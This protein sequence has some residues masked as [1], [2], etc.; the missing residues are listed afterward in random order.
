MIANNPIIYPRLHLVISLAL[1]FTAGFVGCIQDPE[2][3]QTLVPD[4]LDLSRPDDT[5]PD[6]ADLEDIDTDGPCSGCIPGARCIDEECVVPESCHHIEQLG[7]Q[8]ETG[9]HLIDPPQNQGE[10]V[11]AYCDFEADRG[12]GYTMIRLESEDLGVDPNDYRAACDEIGMELIVPRTRVHAQ[13]ILDFNDNAPPNIVG[14]YPRQDGADGL[15]D[16]KGQCQG[17]PC[18]FYIDDSNSPGCGAEFAPTQQETT[19]IP[20]VRSEDGCFFGAWEH[21]T[22]DVPIQG[23][24]IC[25]PNDAGPSFQPTC[26]EYRLHDSV[27]NAGPAGIS[28]LYTLTDSNG[29]LFQTYCEMR[30]HD[31]GWTLIAVNGTD[32]RPENFAENAYPRPGASRYG[33]LAT[34]DSDV[35]AIKNGAE[36]AS[37]FSISGARLYD[38]SDR[39]FLAFVG[40]NTTDYITGQ[41]PEGCNFFDGEGICPHDTF[42]GITVYHSDGSILT[43]DAQACT[44]G[45]GQIEGDIYNEFGLHLIEGPAT[46]TELYH[47]ANGSTNIGNS[48]NIGR[49]YTTFESSGGAYWDQGVLH[50]WN[51]EGALRQPGFLLIR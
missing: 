40:G 47:C 28:G 46:S 8:G 24:V 39:Q 19:H 25:S 35:L 1:V 14:V 31:G 23:S 13:A 30:L 11:V 20:L 51:P 21:G 7:L 42:T 34:M 2:S 5:G 38:L 3:Y 16:W 12:A 36:Q 48:D 27:M 32:G 29:D 17:N 45:A 4:D 10:P 50:Y 41:L 6:D 22:T 33:D 26:S 49:L 37:N 18:S 15:H 44:T 9:F 43:E